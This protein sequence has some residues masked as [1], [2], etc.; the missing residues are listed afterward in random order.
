[1]LRS[2]WYDD[3]GAVISPE[4]AMVG[5][6][7]IVGMLVGLSSLATGVQTEIEDVG[8]AVEAFDFSPTLVP[9]STPPPPNIVE[10]NPGAARDGKPLP[11]G[12]NPRPETGTGVTTVAEKFGEN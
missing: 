6:I 5:V 3:G 9:G 12:P 10:Q 1:M 4:L 8:I 2:L 11:S 7:L